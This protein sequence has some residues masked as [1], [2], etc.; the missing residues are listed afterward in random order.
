[1]RIW[2]RGNHR[3]PSSGVP[4]DRQH[5][6]HPV[7]GFVP[8]VVAGPSPF[9]LSRSPKCRRLPPSSFLTIKMPHLPLSRRNS[10]QLPPRIQRGL[11]YPVRFGFDQ[12]NVKDFKS[13]YNHIKPDLTKPTYII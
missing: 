2:S 12:E 4:A 6:P 7:A 11:P 9:L 10:N 8:V 13:N 1:M 3:E 5:G